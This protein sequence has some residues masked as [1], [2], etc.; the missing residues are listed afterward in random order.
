[1][2]KYM[3]LVR[4][5]LFTELLEIIIRNNSLEETWNK[6][7]INYN[8]FPPLTVLLWQCLPTSSSAKSKLEARLLKL[9]QP[10]C[11]RG[12]NPYEAR[13]NLFFFFELLEA[14]EVL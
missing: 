12:L 13:I 11:H 9:L 1:M 14:H 5:Y 7:S 3:G 4:V 10:H 8:L 2:N 6:L